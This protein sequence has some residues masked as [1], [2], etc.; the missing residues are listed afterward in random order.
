[1][2]YVST[3]LLKIQKTEHVLF[4]LQSVFF[5]YLFFYL[6]NSSLFAITY[7]LILNGKGFYY[8]FFKLVL[9]FLASFLKTIKETTINMA[10]ENLP[11]MWLEQSW[12][13]VQLEC[14]DGLWHLLVP[15]V[16]VYGPRLVLVGW[17]LQVL[18]T[19]SKIPMYIYC[20]SQ[21]YAI[22]NNHRGKIKTL[23]DKNIKEYL[24]TYHR[25][26]T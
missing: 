23:Y 19:H 7:A 9:S 1:M 26:R 13:S 15:S 20:M 11:S 14:E 16:L 22:R 21:Y 25:A 24:Y 5:L 3:K 12:E 10:F 2:N 4:I 6:L 18:K 8:Y 17:Y